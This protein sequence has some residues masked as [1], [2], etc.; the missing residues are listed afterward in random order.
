MLHPNGLFSL[1]LSSL[2]PSQPTALTLG[3][4]ISISVN[5]S[6]IFQLLREKKKK[7]SG[8]SPGLLSCSHT[9][10]P[11]CQQ[12]LLGQS[13]SKVLSLLIIFL[14]VTL[15]RLLHSATWNIPVAYCVSVSEFA[16]SSGYDP[17]K[18]QLA[19]YQSSDQSFSK[20]F[21]PKAKGP[22]DLLPPYVSFI[23]SH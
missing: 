4:L 22:N 17:M 20:V 15:P 13:T 1:K 23:I 10:H 12:I 6:C 5:G 2:S 3:A 11:I 19:S 21:L 14:T 9:P 7:K 16:L 18:I 8:S